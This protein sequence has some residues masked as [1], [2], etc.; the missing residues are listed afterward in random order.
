MSGGGQAMVVNNPIKY[1][2]DTNVLISGLLFNGNERAVL[3]SGREK[4]I[5]LLCSN[6]ILHGFDR[7]L[8]EKF[9]FT[10]NDLELALAY[11]LESIENVILLDESN[12]GDIDLNIR[13]ETDKHIVI[14]AMNESAEIITGDSDLLDQELP[15]K[16]HRCREILD[17]ISK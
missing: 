16:I 15:L 6:L 9:E 7:V 1:V 4:K 12:F 2:V 17:Q 5:T 11:V 3:K 10:P 8:R 14:A 13:D